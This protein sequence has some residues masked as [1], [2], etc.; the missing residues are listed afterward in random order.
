ML[1]SATISATGAVGGPP[2]FVSLLMPLITDSLSEESDAPSLR[3][4]L[5]CWLTMSLLSPMF[6]LSPLSPLSRAR[7]DW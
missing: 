6:P 5:S 3:F 7:R 4:W 2:L 1:T